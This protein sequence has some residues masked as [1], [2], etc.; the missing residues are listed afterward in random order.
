[1]GARLA[2]C[3]VISE[4]D[5]VFFLYESELLPVLRGNQSFDVRNTIADRRAELLRNLEI[6]PPSAIKGRFD[7]E[8]YQPEPVNEDAETLSGLAVSPGIVTGRARV[9]DPGWTPDF[10][11]AAGI[12]VDIG[13]MLSHGSIV[14]REYGK[15][16]VVNVGSATRIIKTGQMVQVDGDQ[17]KV[18]ILRGRD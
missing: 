4:R 16:A 6:T 11:P 1:L 12:V 7:P 14:A 8:R 13:G 3:G 5:D 15:P 9:T 17:G 2:R 18:R 10:L